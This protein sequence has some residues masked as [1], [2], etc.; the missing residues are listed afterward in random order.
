MCVW[1]KLHFSGLRVQPF[2]KINVCLLA[3]P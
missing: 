3:S 1:L 2:E